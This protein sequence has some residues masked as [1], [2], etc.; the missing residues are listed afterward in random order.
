MRRLC[1][2]RYISYGGRKMGMR[3]T[4]M[5]LPEIAEIAARYGRSS[6]PAW[7][8]KKSSYNQTLCRGDRMGLCPH[9]DASSLLACPTLDSYMVQMHAADI[10]KALQSLTVFGERVFTLIRKSPAA[11]AWW[12]NRDLL[13]HR[14]HWLASR[15][16]AMSLIRLT[17]ID[18][19]DASTPTRLSST[20]GRTA[21]RTATGLYGRFSAADT[22]CPPLRPLLASDTALGPG[23]SGRRAGWAFSWSVAAAARRLARFSKSLLLPRAWHGKV[24]PAV[25]ML[26]CRIGSSIRSVLMRVD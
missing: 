18:A 7:R 26:P 23:G 14:R 11:L 9:F 15:R 8:Q 17:G 20:A 10:A 1:L 12:I 19:D 24:R 3:K 13:I 21:A 16:H 5:M 22:D 4:F 6:L 2:L 25:I